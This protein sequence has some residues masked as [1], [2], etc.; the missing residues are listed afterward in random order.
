[1]KKYNIL[2]YRDK[3]DFIISSQYNMYSLEKN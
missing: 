1:M 3:R 2:N